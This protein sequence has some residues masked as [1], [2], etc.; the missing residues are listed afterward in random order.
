MSPLKTYI[1]IDGFNLY[2]GLLKGSPSKWLDID[3]LCRLYLDTSKNNIIKIKY[4]TAL[5][6]SR[7]NDPD[8]HIRQQAYLRALQ[9]IPH[10]E[11]IKGH[12]ISHVVYMPLADGSGY[13]RVIKT[14]EKKSDVNIAVHMLHDAYKNNYDLAVLV[15]NDSDLSESLKIIKEDMGKNIGILNPQ[16]SHSSTE[17]SKYSLFQKKLRQGSLVQCQFPAQLSDST[18]VINKPKK[19]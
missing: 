12:F 10:L 13:A 18:G 9:T 15:S 2:Y 3:K 4:F 1:Y 7:P 5:V 8:Q 16:N 19:W 6:K 11:I 14:E 17:L